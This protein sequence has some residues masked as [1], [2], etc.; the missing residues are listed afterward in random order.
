VSLPNDRLPPDSEEEPV[1]LC[2]VPAELLAWM[3]IAR[4]SAPR[5]NRGSD[6]HRVDNSA[7][8]SQRTANTKRIGID[9][10]VRGKGAA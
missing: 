10:M 2:Y 5:G 8:P 3:P 6:S 9:A 7:P 1:G 4:N